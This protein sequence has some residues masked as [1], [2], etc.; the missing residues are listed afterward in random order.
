MMVASCSIAQVG[1]G[2]PLKNKEQRIQLSEYA[3]HNEPGIHYIVV[4]K[5]STIFSH[6]VGL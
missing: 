4:D 1:N 2:K 6:A 5:Y 3:A